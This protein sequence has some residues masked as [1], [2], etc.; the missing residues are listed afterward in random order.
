MGRGLAQRRYASSVAKERAR[1]VVRRWWSGAEPTAEAVGKVAVTPHPCSCRGCANDRRVEKG[2]KR[3][4]F[5]ERRAR[6]P[7]EAVANLDAEAWQC[8]TCSAP[9]EPNGHHCMACR[10]YWDDAREWSDN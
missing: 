4:T 5:Q 1:R 2:H 3:L 6:D 8:K 10:M 9:A 7:R